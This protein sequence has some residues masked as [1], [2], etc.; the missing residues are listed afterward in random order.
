MGKQQIDYGPYLYT[1]CP[2][3][4]HRRVSHCTIPLE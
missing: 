4:Y 1:F 2:L 3:G